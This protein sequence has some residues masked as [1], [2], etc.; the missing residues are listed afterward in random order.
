MKKSALLFAAFSLTLSALSFAHEYS[1][2]A[3]KIGHPYI[4]PTVASQTNS[5]AYLSLENTGASADVLKEISS[6][7]AKDVEIHTMYMDGDVMKMRDVEK[8][9]VSA[10]AKIEMKP[11]MGYHLMVN[12]LKQPLKIGD[13]IKLVLQ[14]EKAGKVEV[15]AH[16]QVPKAEATMK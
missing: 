7:D 16:V 14:F 15:Q 9:E 2:G 11:G 6:P 5:V 8:L 1:V 13:K 10:K 12:G 4:R 3:I